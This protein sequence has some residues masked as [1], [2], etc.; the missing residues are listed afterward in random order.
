MGPAFRR[1]LRI[2]VGA[3]EAT[4][5]S[6]CSKGYTDPGMPTVRLASSSGLEAS[7]LKTVLA[8]YVDDSP[9]SVVRY[10]RSNPSWI[11]GAGPHVVE[12]FR[13]LSEMTFAAVTKSARGTRACWLELPSWERVS[14]LL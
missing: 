11:A 4:E 9:D 6:P 8:G 5:V 3:L 12:P 13:V 10:L 1:L 14:T 2:R 7:E